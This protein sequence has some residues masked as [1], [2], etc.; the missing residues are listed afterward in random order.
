[1][2]PAGCAWA[3]ASAAR[4]AELRE[5]RALCR[6]HCRA[7]APAGRASAPA[8]CP[9]APPAVPGPACCPHGGTPGPRALPGLLQGHLPAAFQSLPG[10][11]THLHRGSLQG[12][13]GTAPG[14]VASQC[15]REALGCRC[16]GN[17]ASEAAELLALAAHRSCGCP[18]P[19]TA[20]GQAGWGL[21]HPG[22]VEGVPVLGS[23]AG[24]RQFLR[25]LP[26][27]AILGFC[28]HRGWVQLGSGSDENQLGTVSLVE[29]KESVHDSTFT[30]CDFYQ[31]YRSG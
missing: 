21:E 14:P 7:P 27:Q 18:V 3:A 9:P 4:D 8:L 23:R 30:V 5:P 24:T 2:S 19:G 25:T 22:L 28:D 12:P 17:S 31:Y 16:A 1:M 13:A 11:S 29:F 26:S 20:P 15:H 10:P 6:P